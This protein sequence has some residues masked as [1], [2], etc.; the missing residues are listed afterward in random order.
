MLV[1][2]LMIGRDVVLGGRIGTSEA[3]G[4]DSVYT[5]T[6]YCLLVSV[7]CSL[8]SICLCLHQRLSN[9]KKNT[10]S[11][12]AMHYQ[13]VWMA[14]LIFVSGMDRMASVRY[15]ETMKFLITVNIYAND[16]MA[17]FS[18]CMYEFMLKRD[19]PSLGDL[20]CD[21]VLCW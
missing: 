18:S 3:V 5:L 6:A 13:L 9:G 16:C 7:F 20:V 12:K 21:D 10:P 1:H 17:S 2:F 14:F 4:R 19:E 8:A 11:C 15:S